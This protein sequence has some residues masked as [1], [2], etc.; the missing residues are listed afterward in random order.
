MWQT[1]QKLPESRY[2]W[3][4]DRDGM[5][6]ELNL[7]I[8]Q[9]RASG[10]VTCSVQSQDRLGHRSNSE[11]KDAFAVVV[12]AVEEVAAP[13]VMSLQVSPSSI[14]MDGASRRMASTF[15]VDAP[16]GLARTQLICTQGGFADSPEGAS[17]AFAFYYEAGEALPFQESGTVYSP[18]GVGAGPKRDGTRYTLSYSHNLSES[19]PNGSYTCSVIAYDTLGRAADSGPTQIVELVGAAERDT[20]GPELRGLT[21]TPGSV[22]VGRA[23]KDVTVTVSASDPSGVEG[24]FMACEGAEALRAQWFRQANDSSLWGAFTGVAGINYRSEYGIRG[25]DRTSP[26]M[27]ATLKVPFGLAPGAYSCWVSMT[28]DRGNYSSTRV[29]DALMVERT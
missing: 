11:F 29:T 17:R 28:D 18:G 27:A 21:M 1:D 6:F 24:I 13:E 19:L 5:T 3:S 25:G 14:K 12:D 26:T 2:T 7:P 8:G 22:D 9:A 20:D 16:A 23:A 4:R 10:S 15:T